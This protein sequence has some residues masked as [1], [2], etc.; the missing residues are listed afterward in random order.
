M[1][2]QAKLL[3]DYVFSKSHDMVMHMKLVKMLIKSAL[4][5]HRSKNI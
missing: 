1:A 2:F 5:N 3:S 4:P